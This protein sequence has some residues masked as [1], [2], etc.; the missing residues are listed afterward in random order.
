MDDLQFSYTQQARLD[1][2]AA[3]APIEPPNWFVGPT[4]EEMPPPIERDPSAR[5][6]LPDDEDACR[7]IRRW[8][9]TARAF[10]YSAEEAV[11]RTESA[12]AARH[13]R[14]WIERY[15]ALDAD[16][17]AERERVE[18]RNRIAR[19]FAWRRY[20]AENVKAALDEEAAENLSADD[21]PVGD[22]HEPRAQQG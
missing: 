6:E 11:S 22:E 18:H 13:V 1:W 20:Y 8:I 9:G 2:F 12:D 3:N 10:R 15:H 5:P 21:F 7:V 17:Q 16:R 19:Y 4:V 14:E